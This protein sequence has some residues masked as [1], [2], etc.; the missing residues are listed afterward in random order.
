MSLGN[1]QERIITC[2]TGGGILFPHLAYAATLESYEPG[3]CIGYGSTEEEAVQNLVD[4]LDL[5]VA[6]VSIANPQYTYV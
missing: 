5:H 4:Y 2:Q 3:D 6:W 1:G